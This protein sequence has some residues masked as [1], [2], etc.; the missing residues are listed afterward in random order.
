MTYSTIIG[1]LLIAIS[2]TIYY[3]TSLDVSRLFSNKEF[4]V[5]ITGGAG[6]GFILGG[7]LGWLYKYKAENK[8]NAKIA[9]EEKRKIAEQ[10]AQELAAKEQAKLDAEQFK[11]DSGL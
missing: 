3:F 7:F 5:G 10:R 2:A 4:L 9:E 8:A 11:R 6:I 1:V